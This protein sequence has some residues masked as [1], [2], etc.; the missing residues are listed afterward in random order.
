MPTG[1]KIGM[2][3]VPKTAFPCKGTV[4]TW[5]TVCNLSLHSDKIKVV[6]FIIA[7]FFLLT[8]GEKHLWLVMLNMKWILPFTDPIKF[9]H[10]G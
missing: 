3:F 5:Q 2:L 9:I 8:R 4:L 1:E 6:F 7:T 10:N